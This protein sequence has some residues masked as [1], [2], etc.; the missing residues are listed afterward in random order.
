MEAKYFFQDHINIL[1]V[2]LP[3]VKGLTYNQIEKLVSEDFWTNVIRVSRDDFA[4]RLWPK[5]RRRYNIK[6]VFVGDLGSAHMRAAVANPGQE[7]FLLDDGSGTIL[8]Q[9]WFLRRASARLS[10]DDTP[11]DYSTMCNIHAPSLKSWLMKQWYNMLMPMNSESGDIN[12]FT[13][14][15]LQPVGSQKV[16][17]HGFERLKRKKK[18][19]ITD[20]SKVWFFGHDLSWFG[21]SLNEEVNIL[22]QINEYYAARN[23]KVTYMPHR[24]ESAQRLESYAESLGVIIGA[25]QWPAEMETVLRDSL[26][27]HIG[28]YSST[29]LVTLPLLHDFETVTYFRA[30]PKS[31]EAIDNDVAVHDRTIDRYLSLHASVVDLQPLI[32]L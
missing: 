29:A 24:S 10:L 12:L 31:S 21:L 11:Y 14:F 19:K 6:R 17:R 32:P 23:I 27:A 28:A 7:S 4:F 2:I 22:T 9:D 16:I 15:D 3:K 8:T 18:H 13:A 1:V 25:P 26:P 20:S 30:A 5:L